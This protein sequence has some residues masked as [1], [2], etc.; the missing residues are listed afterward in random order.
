MDLRLKSFEEYQKAYQ[1]SVA[2][3]D[4]FWDEIARQFKWDQTL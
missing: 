3:P 4:A 1:K 2:D